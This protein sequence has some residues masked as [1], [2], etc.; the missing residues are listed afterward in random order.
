MAG[1]DRPWSSRKQAYGLS[2][3]SVPSAKV[4]ACHQ[5]CCCCPQFSGPFQKWASVLIYQLFRPGSICSRTTAASSGHLYAR[6]CLHVASCGPWFAAA[7]HVIV[8]AGI[9]SQL[10]E[11]GFAREGAANKSLGGALGF[12]HTL[13]WGWCDL[14]WGGPVSSETVL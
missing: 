9:W 13:A 2:E 6:L 14:R 12:S 8:V 11:A 5:H 3:C 1:K 4:S 10:A 7:H